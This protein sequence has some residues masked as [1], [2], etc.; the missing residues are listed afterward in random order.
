MISS[1]VLPLPG[2]DAWDSGLLSRW[3]PLH[4]ESA[5]LDHCVQVLATCVCVWV[6]QGMGG[7]WAVQGS[8]PQFS[9]DTQISISSLH[10]KAFFCIS[11]IINDV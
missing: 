11:L 4:L 6:W 3:D 1:E 7:Q 8:V 2:P 5:A 10:S 9:G